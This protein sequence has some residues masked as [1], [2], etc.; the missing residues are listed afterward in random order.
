MCSSRFAYFSGLTHRLASD[1]FTRSLI[2]PESWGANNTC[3]LAPRFACA[4]CPEGGS[5]LAIVRRNAESHQFACGT[6]V[7]IDGVLVVVTPYKIDYPGGYIHKP[8]PV[9][10]ARLGR[11]MV[12][13]IYK[14]GYAS[15][16]TII[17][18]GAY[19]WRDLKGHSR[20]RYWLV[21]A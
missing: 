19:E 2:R 3:A 7:E 18:E 12:V 10:A 21:K 6:N 15:Q 9:F 13:C 20:G 11:A 14:E 5:S 1:S 8:R 4:I 17:T 16:E